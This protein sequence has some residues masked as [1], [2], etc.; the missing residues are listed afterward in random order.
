MNT[1]TATEK[2]IVIWAKQEFNLSQMNQDELN[3]L[4]DWVVT[5]LSDQVDRAASWTSG[6]WVMRRDAH[7]RFVNMGLAVKTEVERELDARTSSYQ[8]VSPVQENG[9][10]VIR[11]AIPTEKPQVAGYLN[12]EQPALEHLQKVMLDYGHEFITGVVNE[13]NRIGY[14]WSDFV[15]AKGKKN[16]SSRISEGWELAMNGRV[17]LPNGAYRP[18]LV[19]SQCGDVGNRK[20][21]VWAAWTGF[22]G[23]E[24]NQCD[25][26]DSA[27][28][29]KGYYCKH[30]FSARFVALA[31]HKLANMVSFRQLAEVA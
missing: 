9:R 15:T 12:Q 22:I 14:D 1:T 13:L 27:Y 17:D 4:L 8:E 24:G 28:R 29:A 5:A 3:D 30:V 2:K 6:E 26:E 18:F 31:Y 10:C 16:E 20:Y 21:E 23:H 7:E 25:C 19:D 11:W